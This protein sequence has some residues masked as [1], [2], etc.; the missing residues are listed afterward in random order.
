[1]TIRNTASP[2]GGAGASTGVALRAM[3]SVLTVLVL[4]G[5]DRPGGNVAANGPALAQ[6]KGC[7]ACHG[8]N[9]KGTGPTFPDIN[10]QWASYLRQQLHKYRDGERVN[11]IMNGQA[12]QLSDQDIDILSRYYAAQ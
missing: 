1:M 7:V 5:C 11:A 3:L 6:E 4:T 2:A 12:A 10:G 8:L 9:G